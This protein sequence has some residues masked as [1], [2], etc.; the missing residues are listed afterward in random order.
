MSETQD[1]RFGEVLIGNSPAIRRIYDQLQKASLT[2]VPVLITGES[3]TGKELAAKL[4]HNMSEQRAHSFLKL[5]CAAMSSRFFDWEFEHA[6]DL[7]SGQ[8]KSESAAIDGPM[9]GGTLFLDEIGELDLTLQ[10]KLLHKLQDSRLPGFN[11][12]NEAAEDV[13]LI[14]ATNRDLEAEIAKG[15]FRADLY[16]RIN[17]LRIHM[18]SISDCVTDVPLLM[19]H[20]IK[21]Y[22]QRFG[23]DPIP[24]SESFTKALETHH[25]PGNIRELENMAKRY[26][27][28][29]GEQH[30]LNMMMMRPPLKVPLSEKVDLTTPLRIQTKRVVQHLESKIILSVL[31]AHNWNR[32]KTAQSLDIS[33]R[34]LL[35]KIKEGGLP[36]SSNSTQL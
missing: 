21:V 32:R 34:T 23:K 30:V 10:G 28:L 25:W 35:Y 18:P 4:L 6:S 29:G 26:V 9:S 24:A 20:F 1:C 2:D 12:A 7:I 36:R 22:S 27:V 17:V 31:R 16:Y 33:Y 13:R 15:A 8:Q 3:G 19:K 5:S 14:C 11:G